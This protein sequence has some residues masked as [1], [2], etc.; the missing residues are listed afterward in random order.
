LAGR[1]DPMS[2]LTA[3][4]V[5]R[6]GQLQMPALV[7]SEPPQQPPQHQLP[8]TQSGD[9]ADILRETPFACSELRRAHKNNEMAAHQP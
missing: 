8:E 2:H 3:G 6:Y 7:G 9:V 1:F 5:R 4:F